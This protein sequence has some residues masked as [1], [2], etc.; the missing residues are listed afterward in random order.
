MCCQKHQRRCCITCMA[1]IHNKCGDFVG[2]DDVNVKTSNALSDI[3]E[4]L[5]EVAVNIQQIR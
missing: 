1:E 4:A 5:D 2:L 3:E